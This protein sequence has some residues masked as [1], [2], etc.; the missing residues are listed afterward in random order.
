MQELYPDINIKLFKR[1]E[2][3]SLMVKYGLDEE[4][5]RIIGTEAQQNPT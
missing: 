1:R 2:M 3:R 5:D 4:A